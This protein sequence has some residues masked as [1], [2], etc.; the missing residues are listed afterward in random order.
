MPKLAA[1]KEYLAGFDARTVVG[2]EPVN[3]D[4]EAVTFASE[5]GERLVC[6]VER[7]KE[8]GEY[9]IDS[10]VRLDTQGRRQG[11]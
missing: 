6:V 3:L 1:Y 7:D 10:I 9:L 8:T 4:L 5:S 11:R 2:A